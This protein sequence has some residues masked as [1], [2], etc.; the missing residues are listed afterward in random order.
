MSEFRPQD[1]QYASPVRAPICRATSIIRIATS[2][3][4]ARVSAAFGKDRLNPSRCISALL[5]TATAIALKPLN[6]VPAT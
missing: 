2:S 1:F 3:F 5:S 4:R 6:V